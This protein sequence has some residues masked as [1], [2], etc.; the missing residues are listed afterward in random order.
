[1]GQII[2]DSRSEPYSY[3][4]KQIP[5]PEMELTNKNQAG[6]NDKK[7]HKPCAHGKDQMMIKDIYNDSLQITKKQSWAA[8]LTAT[9]Q[10]EKH[11]SNYDQGTPCLEFPSWGLLSPHIH[12]SLS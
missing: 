8:R 6:L 5:N 4:D 9:L 7:E 1:M 10:S 3:P 2:N 11:P 12:S